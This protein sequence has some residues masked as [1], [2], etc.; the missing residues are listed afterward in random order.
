MLKIPDVDVALPTVV[1]LPT[2]FSNYRSPLILISA[3]A[4]IYLANENKIICKFTNNFDAHVCFQPSTKMI[5]FLFSIFV[6]HF[7]NRNVSKQKQKVHVE[8]VAAKS[9]Y[10]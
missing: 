10:F 1:F 2:L 5:K 4:K 3:A 7:D 6:S 8:S 9:P